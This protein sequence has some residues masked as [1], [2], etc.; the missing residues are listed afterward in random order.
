VGL[1]LDAVRPC[2][3]IQWFL[4]VAHAPWRTSQLMGDH[5]A[6]L[7][8]PHKESGIPTGSTPLHGCTHST[9][10]SEDISHVTRADLYPGRSGIDTMLSVSDIGCWSV[11]TTH[12]SSLAHWIHRI[13]PCVLFGVI[14]LPHGIDYPGYN[15]GST[16]MAI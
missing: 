15:P 11:V 10:A 8:I 12:A 4:R 13:L 2:F 1:A 7:V 16:S 6:S 9:G 14:L 3:S 5:T